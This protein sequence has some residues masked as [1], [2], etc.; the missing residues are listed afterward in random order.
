MSDPIQTGAICSSCAAT[1]SGTAPG[2]ERECY[3]CARAVAAIY[4]LVELMRQCR[5]DA[6][7]P[8]YKDLLQVLGDCT[9]RPSEPAQ[10]AGDHLPGGA[11]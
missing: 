1:L 9:V 5:E 10:R 3:P 7:D 8:T 4:R 2:F 6:R 11:L